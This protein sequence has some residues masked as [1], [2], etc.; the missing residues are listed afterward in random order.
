MHN[1]DNNN[2]LNQKLKIKS[3]KQNILKDN[4]LILVLTIFSII[5]TGILFF[6]GVYINNSILEGISSGL[7]TAA[8]VSLV[9]ILVRWKTDKEVEKTI[10]LIESETNNRIRAIQKVTDDM[11]N[12]LSEKIVAINLGIKKLDDATN[13]FSKILDIYNGKACTF[14]KNY[15]KDVKFNRKDCN[16]DDFFSSAKYSIN[17]LATN[18]K[19][20]TNYIPKLLEKANQGIKVRIATM[21]PNFAR[22]FNISRVTGTTTA[23]QRWV[24]MKESLINFVSFSSRSDV[25][26]DKFQVK[27]YNGIAPTL[28]LIMVDNNCYVAYLINGMHARDTIHFLFSTNDNTNKASPVYYFKNHFESIWEDEQTLACSVKELTTLEFDK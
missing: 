6:F 15:I 2:D 10:N 19:S 12:D 1:Q 18:L 22:D 7:F 14:C 3:V 4:R 28:I 16:L 24:D 13:D 11:K 27:A 8:I 20:F 9:D 23:E 21:H 5:V 17:I 26:K 25:D